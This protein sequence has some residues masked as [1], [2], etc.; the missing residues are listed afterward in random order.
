MSLPKERLRAT[1]GKRQ[2]I[3]EARG[4]RQGAAS[5]GQARRR[6]SCKQGHAG[7][8]ADLAAASTRSMDPGRL[9]RS[10]RRD[11]TESSPSA[12]ADC[13][14]L[15]SP[16]H[17]GWPSDSNEPPRIRAPQQTKKPRTSR[18]AA[19]R[20]ALRPAQRITASRRPTPPPQPALPAACPVRCRPPA[21]CRAGRRP[22]RPPAARR[23]S[24]VRRPSPACSPRPSRRRS[25]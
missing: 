6:R 3:K 11:A 23:S 7:R 24:R 17:P 13:C 2:P 5:G 4:R 18:L 1:G 20:K 8:P 21:P 9:G 14:G 22:C 12:S 15:D 10:P 25:G 16:R 19:F